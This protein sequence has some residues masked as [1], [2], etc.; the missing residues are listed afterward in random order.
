[1]SPFFRHCL[2]VQCPRYRDPL[3]P[4]SRSPFSP[5]G[6][7]N[8]MDILAAGTATRHHLVLRMND[9]AEIMVRRN[10]GHRPF[11]SQS[12]AWME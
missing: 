5:S 11:R 3:T 7:P 8:N 1:M 6:P 9:G 10:N 12:L 4:V 2:R